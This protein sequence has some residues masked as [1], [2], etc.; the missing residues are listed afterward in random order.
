MD[1]YE[2]LPM[3]MTE[4][5]LVERFNKKWPHMKVMLEELK[6]PLDL[7]EPSQEE[8][9]KGLPVEHREAFLEAEEAIK[10]VQDRVTRDPRLTEI[11]TR[12][13]KR[14]PRRKP[15]SARTML[16]K[17]AVDAIEAN[18][19]PVGVSFE[20]EPEIFNPEARRLA[21]SFRNSLYRLLLEKAK[22]RVMIRVVELEPGDGSRY[23]VVVEPK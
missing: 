10:R 13:T 15:A 18:D 3:E 16:L 20:G 8:R 7:E 22:D 23:A 6:A 9:L 14:P 1:W 11:Q 19:L 4:E 2:S 17:E 12:R 5:E 21:E